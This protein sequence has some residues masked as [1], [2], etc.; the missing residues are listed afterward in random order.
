MYCRVEWESKSLGCK[1]TITPL[2]GKGVYG[3]GN[4]EER[5]IGYYELFSL[6]RYLLIGLQIAIRHDYGLNLA[7][8]DEIL[9]GELAKI[10]VTVAFQ[11]STRDMTFIPPIGGINN[12]VDITP[13]LN[14]KSRLEKEVLAVKKSA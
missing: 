7:G 11:N 14:D 13:Y 8:E 6:H 2:I 5:C 3:E 12:I 4:N 9:T 1:G 10:P